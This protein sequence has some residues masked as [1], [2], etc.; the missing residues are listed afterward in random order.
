MAH[1]MIAE[2]N[3]SAASYL[4]KSLK[5]EGNTVTI[6]DNSIDAWTTAGGLEEYDIMMIDVVMPGLDG[7][8][9]AQKALQANP[10]LQIIFITGFAAVAMDTYNTPSYAP[11]PMTS[12]PFHL[13]D[14]PARVH[15]M[16][17]EADI[18]YENTTA[19]NSNNVVYAEFG[20]TK[21]G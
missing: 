17:G 10:G 13:K 4:Y 1:I 19:N 3:K 21:A 8:V 6:A 5:Q 7:F 9:L 11:S 15:Y 12:R 2:H 20:Q 16:M 18:P 14:M